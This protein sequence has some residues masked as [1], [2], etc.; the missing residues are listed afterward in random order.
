MNLHLLYQWE[1]E[2][3]SHLTSLNQWQV[4]NLALFSYGVILAESSQLLKIARKVLCGEQEASAEKRLRRLISNSSL[5]L[6]ET[7]RDWGRWVLGGLESQTVYLL[8]DETKLHERLGALV[9]GVAWEGRCI[10]LAWRCY[11]ANSAADYPAEGQVKLIEGLLSRL[12]PSIPVGRRVIV[13]ADRGIGTSP[14]LCRAVERLGWDYL[15]RVTGQTKIVTA[16]GEYT[17]A[18]QVDPGQI[19]LAEGTVFKRRGRIPAYACALWAIGYDEPWAL[20]TNAP[21]LAGVEYACRN[22][23]EQSFRDLKSAGW[24]WA[25]SHV[26]QPAHM[27]RL[28]LLL[29]LAY[30]W[31]LALGSYATHWRR[32]HPVQRHANGPRRY[33][34]LFKEGQRL[35][36]E[37]VQRK[38][39]CLTLCFIAI[40]PY[41]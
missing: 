12:K 37:Y 7:Q 9:V 31:M 29:V 27:E 16:D 39:I 17:I 40:Q 1:E 30:G 6:A 8:V 25:T 2:I 36:V 35:F 22:W 14:D 3:A 38:T 5:K 10:P 11:K 26:R 4:V 13:L 21:D 34:S 33:W 23:Q 32:V 41:P 28:L 20:V 15:F 18:Q 24:Q 19:W